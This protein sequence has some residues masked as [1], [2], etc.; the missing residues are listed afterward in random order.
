MRNPG[1]RLRSLAARVFSAAT[2][3]RVIDPWLAD[4]EHEHAHAIGRRHRLRRALMLI[5][6]YF[7]FWKVVGRLGIGWA[8][9]ALRSWAAA[10]DRAMRSRH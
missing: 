9:G 1:A 10:D 4:L 5:E 2:M 7:A 6:A 8:T 3:E